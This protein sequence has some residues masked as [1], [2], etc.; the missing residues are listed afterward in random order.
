MKR[1]PHLS[2]S[3]PEARTV[4]TILRR[5]Q[6][7]GGAY[8]LPC[9]QEVQAVSGW[10]DADLARAIGQSLGVPEVQVHN[11]LEFYS[12]LYNQPVG[13]HI[14]RVCD[15]PACL[16]TGSQKIIR[17]CARHLGVPVSGGT[18]A[19]GEITLEIHPCLGHC[20]QA[21]FMMVDDQEIGHVQV[22]QIPEVL[23]IG[24]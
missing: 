18:T 5:Y 11:V 17:A 1:S 2:L 9:L 7:R 23:E 12:L 3:A 6:Q 13:K 4:Q 15:D 24:S 19:D 22:E 8:L 14:V 21:P 20:E 16:V 10:I